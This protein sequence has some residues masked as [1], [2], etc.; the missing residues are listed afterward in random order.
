[1]ARVREHEIELVAEAMDLLASID[2]LVLFG[3]SDPTKRGGLVSFHDPKL[4][5]HD[6]ATFLDHEG[7]AVRVGNHCAQPLH[8]ALGV[9]GTTR[10]SIGIYS[11][12]A[13]LEALAAGIRSA[14]KFFA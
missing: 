3:P 2:G 5:P 9:D 1:M 10:A 7:I 4:H 8:R 11:N 6:L 12:R 13:D 14:R